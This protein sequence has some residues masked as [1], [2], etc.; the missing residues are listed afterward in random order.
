MRKM[1]ERMPQNSGRQK[2]RMR[3]GAAGVRVTYGTRGVEVR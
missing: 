3:Q 2:R 1:E